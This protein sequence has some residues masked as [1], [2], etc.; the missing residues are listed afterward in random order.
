[1]PTSLPATAITGPTR[2]ARRNHARRVAAALIAVVGL[3]NLV[4]A[5]IPPARPRLRLLLD[6]LPV[7]APQ[8]ASFLTS[9]AGIGLLLLGRGVRKGQRHAWTLAVGLMSLSV[10]LHL[11]KGLD[12]EEAL[13]AAAVLGYLLVHREAFT[14]P[15]DRASISRAAAAVATGGALALVMG[16]I[17]ALWLP[18]GSHMSVRDAFLACAER[19]VGLS[20]IDIP[21]RR[22]HFLTPALGGVG[23][24]LAVFAGWLLFRPVLRL[25]TPGATEEFLRARSIVAR[26]GGD[27]LAYFALRDDKERWYHLDS[28]VAYAVHNGVCLISPDPIGP[29][30]QRAEVLQEF[31]QFASERAWNIAV[32]AAAED[33]LPIYRRAGLHDLY[34]GDEAIVDCRTFSLEGGKK[35]GLRQAVNRIAK[36]GYTIEFRDPSS[37]SDSIRAE[38]RALMTESRRGEVERGFSMT[39]GR[40]FE[41]RDTGLLLA[42]CRGPHGAAAAFCQYVPAAGIGGYSLDLMRRSEAEDHPNGLTDFVVVRT[43]EY[44]RDAGF[45]RLGLNFAVMR[46]VL[47]EE[48]AGLGQRAQRRVLGWLSDSMQIESLWKYNAK[49]EPEWRPRYGVYDSLEG[50]VPAAFAIAKAESFWELPIVGRFL[51]PDE[52][53]PAGEPVAPV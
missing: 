23:L 50:F 27:T 52:P 16:T 1:M 12:V 51:Q 47:S 24:T 39:L 22:E 36:Y 19:L 46:S 31:Q 48:P 5:L 40:V 28:M 32:M 41:A 34:I 6:A 43:I 29:V 17:T 26:H 38:L 7:E 4:S 37:L 30:S 35:K 18:D 8:T 21:A 33:W 10:V 42:I 53:P 44:L 9:A 25:R 2:A 15:A 49:F 45:A 13:V 14:A 11:V 3:L 20:T